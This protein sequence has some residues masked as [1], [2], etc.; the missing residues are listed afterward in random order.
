MVNIQSNSEFAS[1]MLN[2]DTFSNEAVKE[3]IA[4]NF[5]LLQ[6]RSTQINQN[7]RQSNLVHC[8]VFL[9]SGHGLTQVHICKAIFYCAIIMCTKMA[10]VAIKL[11]T[12]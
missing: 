3:L 11:V 4:A 9:C 7:K 5:I 12:M 6:V 1:H 10:L 8:H 2:R